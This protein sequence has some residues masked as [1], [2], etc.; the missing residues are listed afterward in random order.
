ML[1]CCT[2]LPY[3]A[4]ESV[5]A[6]TSLLEVFNDASEIMGG[7]YPTASLL[8]LLLARLF[9]A[10]EVV[11]S[12][13]YRLQRDP[14]IVVEF[15]TALRGSLDRVRLTGAS[16]CSCCVTARLCTFSAVWLVL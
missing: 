7:S 2:E 14:P 4:R 16:L 10:V 6:L 9:S 3:G 11:T 8:P 12:S 5:A 1:L 13:T 15:K